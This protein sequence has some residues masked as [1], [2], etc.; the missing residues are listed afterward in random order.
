MFVAVAK[1]P[2]DPAAVQ[3][4]AGIAGLA[5]ADASRFLAGPLPRIL[6]RATREGAEI[7]EALEQAGFVAF[8]GEASSILSDRERVLARNLE[9][10]PEAL[11]ALDGRG[12]RHPC[13]VAAI[14]AYLR[15]IR[16]VETTEITKTTERKLDVGKALLTSGLSVT[17][18]VET[19]SQRTTSAKEP[20]LLIQRCDGLPGIMLYEHQLNYQCLGRGLQPSTF[21]NFTALLARLRTLAPTAPVDDR[22]TRPGFLAGLPKLP[23]ETVDLALFLVT[24]ARARRC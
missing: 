8:I 11:V 16:L 13:P 4:A 6:V 24:E 14:S 22:I 12:Q 20:F 3:K 7:V 17:K 10:A 5:M 18:K 9:L 23:V 19:I 15:G 2:A 21:G 1:M